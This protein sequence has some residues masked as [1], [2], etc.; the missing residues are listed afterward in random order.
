MADMSKFRRDLNL[1]KALRAEG[2]G[3]K[4][5]V[6]LPIK[7]AGE[8]SGEFL[9]VAGCLVLGSA[10]SIPAAKSDALAKCESSPQVLKKSFVMYVFPAQPLTVVGEA[11]ECA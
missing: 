1:R 10:G 3:D 7:Q 11:A 4:H 5:V 6:L 9:I 8:I 2:F